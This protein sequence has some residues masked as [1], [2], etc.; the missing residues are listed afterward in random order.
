MT[1]VVAESESERRRI[2]PVFIHR[3]P[4]ERLPP[5]L[6]KSAGYDL[7]WETDNPYPEI[8]SLVSDISKFLHSLKTEEESP[9]PSY[10]D[11]PPQLS[12]VYLAETT[13]ELRDERDRLK[14]RLEAQGYRVLPDRPLPIT[15][16][17]FKRAVQDYLRISQISI[18]LL[19]QK[20]GSYPDGGNR[21]MPELQFNFAGERITD[22]T[23]TRIVWMPSGAKPESTRQR[24]L[25]DIAVA[26]QRQTD[27]LRTS[28]EDLEDS[29]LDRLERLAES[30]K[31]V[32][33]SPQMA[34]D[35]NVLLV[36][37]HKDE[38]FRRKLLNHLNALWGEGLITSM[39]D[40]MVAPGFESYA[41]IERKLST[42]NLVLLLISSTFLRSDFAFGDQ[43]KRAIEGHN[44]GSVIV[45]PILVHPVSLG[46]S[47]YSD[48]LTLPSNYKA[49]SE[50]ANDDQAYADIMKT[51]RTVIRELHARQAEHKPVNKE[52]ELA[53]RTP[54]RWPVRT[55][56][57]QDVSKVNL[58]PVETTIQHL[59]DQMRPL[60]MP[61][62]SG[63]ESKYHSRRAE[64]V[65]TTV[66][67]VNA[68]IRAFKLNPSESYLL[69]LEG[70]D[71]VTMRAEVPD[72][73][74]A[75][76][77]PWQE[78]F[79]RVRNKLQEKLPFS[80]SFSYLE[81]SVNVRIWG[82]GFFSGFHGQKHAA[83]N[84]IELQPILD[85][86]WLPNRS[87]KAPRPNPNPRQ[88]KASGLKSSKSV[89]K[90]SQKARASNSRTTKPKTSKT[91][92]PASSKTTGAAPSRKAERPSSGKSKSVARVKTSRLSAKKQASKKNV[93][94]R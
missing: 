41:D 86:E 77:S 93:K 14:R 31:T 90:S 68:S 65:E 50:W 20:Y 55:G 33:G 25:F 48:L 26:E 7:R 88:K 10:D 70:R 62:M 56:T 74:R 66:W 61:R 29:L 16:A 27:V 9:A 38:I 58:N 12:T 89:T 75:T 34:T 1:A 46:E 37:E 28:P 21:S 92:R 17:E 22:L 2:F 82:V 13:R 18:H 91:T 64:P 83:P 71:G 30:S 80:S 60:D 51:M 35:I 87:L 5:S 19:G 63:V 23:F 6:Q 67:S 24:Q 57:D 85:I 32:T 45:L 52:P 76:E 73:L 49:I 84:G 69:I 44:V 4:E 8:D 36:Y 94:K 79:A 59:I 40:L 3:V 81:P 53:Q 39:Q 47:L 42:S 78:S 43:I 54:E 72:P 15:A 11:V